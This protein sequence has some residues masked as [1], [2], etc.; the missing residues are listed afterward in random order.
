MLEEQGCR[1]PSPGMLNDGGNSGGDYRE[2]D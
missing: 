1:S 2:P